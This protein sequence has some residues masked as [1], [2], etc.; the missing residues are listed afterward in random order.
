MVPLRCAP[1]V[2]TGLN[3]KIKTM[4]ARITQT[5]HRLASS[6]VIK[7][8]QADILVS[9]LLMNSLKLLSGFVDQNMCSGSEEQR[10]AQEERQNNWQRQGKK[11]T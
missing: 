6:H 5:S 9:Q 4:M 1:L 10:H 7:I 2:G 11:G 8:K 3:E